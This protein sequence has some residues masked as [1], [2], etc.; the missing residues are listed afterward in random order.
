[1]N[2]QILSE[3]DLTSLLSLS[4]G[5]IINEL[6]KRLIEKLYNIK[7]TEHMELNIENE[8]LLLNF[9]DFAQKK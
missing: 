4:S 8:D 3:L 2:H 9:L 5:T 1:M 7:E 6:H